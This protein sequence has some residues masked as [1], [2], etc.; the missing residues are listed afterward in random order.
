[1]KIEYRGYRG[2]LLGCSLDQRFIFAYDIVKYDYA[3][4][5]FSQSFVCSGKYW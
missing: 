5:G 3:Y 4:I 2:S 1:M